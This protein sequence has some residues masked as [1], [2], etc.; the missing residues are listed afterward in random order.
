MIKYN[1]I[2]TTCLDFG[3]EDGIVKYSI[4]MWKTPSL[5]EEGK[6]LGTLH[7]KG[8]DLLKFTKN[9]E[10]DFKIYTIIEAN[11]A[12]NYIQ[13]IF[14]CIDYDEARAYIGNIKTSLE[15]SN[16][17]DY[18][19]ETKNKCILLS[20]LTNN[21]LIPLKKYFLVICE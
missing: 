20:E 18:N 10:L 6:H 1:E 12:S 13:P 5:N 4:D 11:Y 17:G 15:E 9:R 7:F 16:K 14:T 19:L 2:K 3:H 21:E 8:M